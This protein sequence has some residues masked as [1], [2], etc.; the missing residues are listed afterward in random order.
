M[1]SEG[2]YFPALLLGEYAD[3][4]TAMQDLGINGQVAD[5]CIF[6]LADRPEHPTIYEAELLVGE[7]KTN[8]ILVLYMTAAGPVR[9]LFG[10]PELLAESEQEALL[11]ATKALAAGK[12]PAGDFGEEPKFSAFLWSAPR[13]AIQ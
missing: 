4:Y 10:Y 13:G 12:I 11:L 5:L 2:K 6:G 1:Y 7:T 3:A 8:I 9:I